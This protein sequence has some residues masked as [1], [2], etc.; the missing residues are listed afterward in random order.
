MADVVDAES[1]GKVRAFKKEKKAAAKA[2]RVTP[3][4][5]R[6]AGIVCGSCGTTPVTRGG[7][8]R[9]GP[10]GSSVAARTG[11][12]STAAAVYLRSIEGKLDSDRWWRT[13]HR[14][15]GQGQSAKRSSGVGPPVRGDA[16][17][18][19]AS[20][21]RDPVRPELR[22]DLGAQLLAR[23]EVDRQVERRD[24]HPHR[25]P[26]PQP[27]L[28][29][30]AARVP[31]AT[32]SNASRSKSAPS[33][34]LSTRSTLRL[35]SAVTPGRVVVR[36]RPAPPGPSPGRCRAA[37]SRPASSTARSAA[38]TRPARPGSR[39]PIVPPRNATSRR[40]PAGQRGPGAGE[41]ADDA[42]HARGP[43][44]RR[45]SPSA[46]SRSA[47]SRDVQRDERRQR[48]GRRAARPA[49]AGSSPTSRSPAR[50]GS[51][52]PVSRGDLGGPRRPGSPARPGSGSTR[53]A[54]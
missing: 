9:A 49:A 44:S 39:L 37:A 48:A 23:G 4:A 12:A 28:D 11:P 8:G 2:T 22:R 1:L 36:R 16:N 25:P 54:G 40:P 10:W 34:R 6:R 5:R 19:A 38:G 32:C 53:A 30:L 35:N 29:P 18:A 20:S 21:A 33:S 26:R 42:V 50:P 17:P 47:D 27:H 15:C 45:R 52:A 14:A 46:A 13:L 51:C 3:T 43:G 7:R 31:E 24:P 41:V